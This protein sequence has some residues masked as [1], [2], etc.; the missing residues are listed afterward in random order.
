MVNGIR[1]SRLNVSSVNPYRGRPEKGCR[2]SLRW[3]RYLDFLH[4]FRHPLFT[5]YVSEHEQGRRVIGA[6]RYVE[7]FDLHFLFTSLTLHE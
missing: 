1:Y 6:I 3:I 4:V 7:K 2:G 5:E